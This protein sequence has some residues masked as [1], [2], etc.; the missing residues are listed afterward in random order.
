[1]H[2]R[3]SLVKS[4]NST[5]PQTHDVTDAIIDTPLSP[6]PEAL[7]AA[8]T[9]PIPVKDA[10]SEMLAKFGENIK[11]KKVMLIDCESPSADGRRYEIAAY[12]HGAI[13][14][15]GAVRNEHVQAG[16][17]AGAVVFDVPSTLNARDAKTVFRRVA[18]NVVAL[19]PVCIRR[20]DAI[21]NPEGKVVRIPFWRTRCFWVLKKSL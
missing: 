20:A 21:P 14:S 10:L 7:V 2:L 15:P 1:M 9:I 16:R 4:T 8:P 3:D 18:S 6:N 12:V 19:P 5:Q 11:I 13:V 17:L